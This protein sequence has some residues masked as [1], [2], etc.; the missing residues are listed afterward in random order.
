MLEGL[1][2]IDWHALGHAYGRADNIPIALRNLTSEDATVRHQAEEELSGTL[3]HQGSIYS[4][5]AIAVSFLTD[6]ILN[7]RVLERDRILFLLRMFA[8]DCHGYK[9]QP[10]REDAADDERAYNARFRLMLQGA[11]DSVTSSAAALLDLTQQGDRTLGLKILGLLKVFGDGSPPIAPLLYNYLL[12]EQD[13]RMLAAMVMCLSALQTTDPAHHDACVALAR[14]DRPAIVRLAAAYATASFMREKTP[15]DVI[16]YLV[17]TVAAPT[18]FTSLDN[19][20]KEVFLSPDYEDALFAL[21]P[22]AAPRTVPLLIGTLQQADRPWYAEPVIGMLIELLFPRRQDG[23]RRV[24]NSDEWT[25]LQRQAVA[26]AANSAVWPAPGDDVA[27]YSYRS[28]VQAARHLLPICVM[29]GQDGKSRLQPRLNDQQLAVLR[30]LARAL[31]IKPQHPLPDY[32]V[33]RRILRDNGLPDT[34]TGLAALA[35]A[36][37]ALQERE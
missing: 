1:G 9:N 12:S 18:R 26:T 16:D 17:A 33:M 7:P 15:D 5:T 8:W 24:P 6:L 22:R 4:A 11:C 28:T 31:E 34:A 2:E 25:A 23:V 37:E 36:G 13:P 3:H 30:S 21:G 32:D 29:P 27:W 35:D 10:D 20:L 14:S 19:L